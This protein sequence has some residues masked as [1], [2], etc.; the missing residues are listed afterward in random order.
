MVNV[1]SVNFREPHVMGILNVTPDSFSDGADLYSNGCVDVSKACYRVE[2]MLNEGASIIDVGGESTKP[3][4]A[5]VSAEEESNRVL[6]VIEALVARFDTLISI[7][8]SSP[9]L[10]TQAVSL[11]A[12]LVNDVR[13]LTRE[14]AVE[15][16][17][18]LDVPVVLMHSRVES[19]SLHDKVDASTLMTSMMGYFTDRIAAFERAGIARSRLL[20]DP[21]F[22][23]GK[24]A[25]ENVIL[26]QGLHQLKAFDLPVLVG[27]SRK[28][29]I[30]T[31]LGGQP[32]KDRM[33]GSITLAV[34]AFQ[35]GATIIR[36]HDVGETV[37]ALRIAE[38][39][40]GDKP[41]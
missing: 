33:V 25:E 4:A 1:A 13:G 10:M 35:Q 8:S 34:L 28:K 6:P 12:G 21:G 14:G 29:T 38:I 40:L 23:F 17:A 27:L 9:I 16:C 15:A 32:P 30:S 3:G 36:A 19:S 26:M 2:E 24:Q 20:I 41:V 7:D 11:G 22:G 31:F 39:F 37:Q 18:S 5:R